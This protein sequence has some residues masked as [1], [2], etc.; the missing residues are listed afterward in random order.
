MLLL[1]PFL[2]LLC[3]LSLTYLISSHLIL[4]TGGVYRELREISCNFV[5]TTPFFGIAI[6]GCLGD[7]KVHMHDIVAYTRSLLR[8]DKPIHL[9]GIGGV[10]DIFHGVRL[11]IDTFDCVHP[12]RLG[13]H[14]GALVLASYWDEELNEQPS[15]AVA[16]AESNRVAKR[17]DK[18]EQRKI[19]KMAAYRSA[20][21]QCVQAEEA[22]SEK[23]DPE[24]YIRNCI[25]REEKE[26]S[27]A[28][29]AAATT[30]TTTTAAD[31][32]VDVCI[33]VK[34]KK[35]QPLRMRII[36]EHMNVRKAPMR[37]DSRPIDITC[38]CYTCKNFSRAYLHHLFKAG[39][40]LGGTLVT[41]HNV[42][43]MSR[44]MKDIR[45]AIAYEQGIEVGNVGLEQEGDERGDGLRRLTLAEV[46]AIYVHHSIGSSKGLEA[47]N[48]IGS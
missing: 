36:R 5:N 39:E 32:D 37:H 30:A 8:N 34:H 35:R 13:R 2:F 42:H 26:E 6:G 7:T 18:E 48:S 20:T 11:G 3:L 41:I 25:V 23:Q 38:N 10:R 1:S 19:Q 43:F 40:S 9:L 45:H 44:L 29:A 16:L 46:E 31:V 22:G 12:T 15:T 28:A 14:G 27:T 4:S 47:S 24:E 33:S 17:K 21:K